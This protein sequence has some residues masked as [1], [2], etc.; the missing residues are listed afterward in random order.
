MRSMNSYCLLGLSLPVILAQDSVQDNA[1]IPDCGL[2][3]AVSSTS[4]PDDPKWGIYAGNTLQTGDRIGYGELAIPTFHLL[5]NNLGLE[6]S[7]PFM[8]DVV[9]FMEQFMWIPQTSGA[10]FELD[11]GG[12]VITVV[13]GTGIIGGFH[14]QLTNADWNHAMPLHR[15]QWGETTGLSHPGR[16]ASSSY[17]EVSLVATQEINPGMEIFVHYGDNWSEDGDNPDDT[18]ESSHEITKDDFAKI[19]ETVAQMIEFFDKYQG[20]LDEKSKQE[21]YQFLLKDVMAAAAGSKKG[22]KIARLLPPSPD[23]LR[24]FQQQG[25]ATQAVSPTSTRPLTWLAQ[26]G[27]CMDNLRPGPSD[28]PHAGRGAFATRPLTAGAT[29]APIPIVHVAN[30]HV[31]DMYPLTRTKDEHDQE[32]FVRQPGAEV[33]DVQLLYNY[34]F[35]HPESDIVLMP[36]GAATSFINHSP[37][38]NAKLVWSQHPNHHTHWFDMT[39]EQLM[40]QE[41]QHLGLLMEVQAIR[42]IVPGEEVTID[43]GSDWVQSWEEHNRH[44]EEQV[45]D[46]DLPSTWPVRAVDMNQEYLD[47][48]FEIDAEYPQTVLLKCFLVV[49]PPVDEPSINENGEKVRLWADTPKTLDSENLFDCTVTDRADV[50]ND[51]G[52]TNW[53]YTVLWQSDTATTWVK[54]VPH[55]AIVFVDRP[56]MSDHHFMAGFRHYIEIPDEIFPQG[57]WRNIMVDEASDD[58]D[59]DDIE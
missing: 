41:N 6:E 26:H 35:G 48:P 54:E 50:T 30:E 25:G 36:A 46:G 37:D 16:G 57:P 24:D 7:D 43:Y 19:D 34:V 17:Y 31:L 42:D 4:T 5:S 56:G 40:E 28:I 38:P 32:Y 22:R 45:Q 2:Y 59:D 14:P 44:W 1:I 8:V 3:L 33:A 52:E 29:I 9:D 27:I 55:N 49:K 47:K 20:D 10:Q 21:I 11:D 13:P 12:R 58:D 53:Q 23:F 39:P 18:S 15:P 51:Q